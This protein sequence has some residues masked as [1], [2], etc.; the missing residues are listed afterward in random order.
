M[1]NE[2]NYSEML[3]Q[4]LLLFLRHDFQHTSVASIIKKKSNFVVIFDMN[5]LLVVINWKSLHHFILN[6]K[7]NIFQLLAFLMLLKYF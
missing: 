2:K 4:L 3:I 5:L 6:S 1:V 7:T